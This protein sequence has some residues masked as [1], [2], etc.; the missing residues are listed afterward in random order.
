MGQIDAAVT[1]P[2]ARIRVMLVDDHAIVRS[3]FRRLLDQYPGIQVIVEAATAERAYR[4]FL[5]YLPDVLVLDISMPGVGGVEIMRRVLARVPDAKIIVFSMHDDASMA[6]RAMRI[7]ARGYVSKSNNPE[8]LAQAVIEVAAGRQFLSPDI[9]HTVAL[10]MFSGQDDP[11]ES[12]TSR[13]F[14][15]FRQ[16]VAGR[17]VPEIAKTLDLS[18]KTIANYHT[19]IKQKLGVS[20]DVEL[21]RIAM[22]FNLL[23]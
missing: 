8:V 11:L 16:I 19:A 13:E 9:A 4:D 15:V 12:L 3:G 10:S 22:R 18:G 21:V 17:T 14:E 1:G 5:E 2:S 6:A 23:S 7:G 20:S